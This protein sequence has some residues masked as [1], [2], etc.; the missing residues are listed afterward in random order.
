MVSEVL[1]RRGH[2]NK[3]FRWELRGAMWLF[4]GGVQGRQKSQ[5]KGPEVG[6]SLECRRTLKPV[7]LEGE[8]WK[9]TRVGGDGRR[10]C[11]P[12]VP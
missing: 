4:R 11:S 2:F 1:L 8:V 10:S 9:E 3:G 6:T 5:C 12:G 7:W